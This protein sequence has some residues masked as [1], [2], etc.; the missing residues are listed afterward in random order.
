MAFSFSLILALS[1]INQFKVKG[2]WQMTRVMLQEWPLLSGFPL[3]LT[4]D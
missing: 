4:I 1:V 3:I 2:F